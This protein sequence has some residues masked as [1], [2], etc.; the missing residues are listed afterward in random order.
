MENIHSDG[1]SGVSYTIG[2]HYETDGKSSW[3]RRGLVIEDAS[4]L[5]VWLS[6]ATDM[7]EKDM[8]TLC[9]SRLEKAVKAGWEKVREEHIKEHRA[10]MEQC[11]F[12][13][14]D[15]NAHLSTDQ[16]I[17]LFAEN[18]G[19]DE[20]LIALFFQYGR[21]LIFNSSRPD[22]L[23]PAALQGIW[24]DDRACRMEW[25]DDMHLDI[26][27]QMN[28]YP[29]ENTGLGECVQPLFRWIR[30]ISWFPMGRK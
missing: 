14:P 15:T 4:R 7:F 17:R 1:V 11:M 18:N 6:A 29:A 5:T 10:G 8:E 24:N 13:M 27:T 9:S 3:N 28:Y 19:G 22:S 30:D 25:T 23:L 21:Y 26:N 20:G 16:R 12:T 2:L